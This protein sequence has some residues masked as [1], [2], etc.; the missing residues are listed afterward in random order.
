MDSHPGYPTRGWKLTA[1][2]AESDSFSGGELRRDVGLGEMREGESSRDGWML[3]CIQSPLSP[4]GFSLSIDRPSY[5]V[6]A[7]PP[8]F[9]AS[10]CKSIHINDLWPADSFRPG[11]D[12]LGWP[13]FPGN[14]AHPK[15]LFFRSG[16]L[17][18]AENGAKI[19][20]RSG[21]VCGARRARGGG[22]RRRPHRR[23]GSGYR[24]G[25]RRCRG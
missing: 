14:E 19:R 23:C 5:F 18:S 24:G 21:P 1:L 22:S 20:G 3:V 15:A 11:E 17:I 25:R 12:L 6:K 13:G 8:F 9:S 2:A 16:G 7:H 10:S 4:H